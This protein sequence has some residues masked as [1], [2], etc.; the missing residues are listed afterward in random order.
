MDV[1]NYFTLALG[2]CSLCLLTYAT[3]DSTASIFKRQTKLVKR[4]ILILEGTNFGKFT[5][6]SQLIA[7]L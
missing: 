4:N 6:G 2:N 3:N 5:Y 7:R 1:C